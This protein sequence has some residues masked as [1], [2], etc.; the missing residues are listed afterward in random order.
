M[1]RAK[2]NQAWVEKSTGEEVKIV[3]ANEVHVTYSTLFSQYAGCDSKSF[4]KNFENKD[5]QLDLF[6]E[7]SA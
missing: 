3:A 2:K 1:T 4:Y 6:G 7:M 5:K